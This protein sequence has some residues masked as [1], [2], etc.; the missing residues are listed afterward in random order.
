MRS[1]QNDLY[2][3]Y[4]RVIRSYQ[5]DLYKSYKRVI[6]S[7][8]NDLYKSYKRVIRRSLTIKSEGSSGLS[9]VFTSSN[10]PYS[11][12]GKKPRINIYL[13]SLIIQFLF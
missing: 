7:Y 6:R 3:S 4:K 10:A 9:E 11:I 1:Y 5:N 13:S 12:A 8:Q 2:I